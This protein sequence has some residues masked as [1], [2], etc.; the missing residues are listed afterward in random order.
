MSLYVISDLHG[1]YDLL[2]EMLKVINFSSSD[3]M[4]ILGDVV[5]RGNKPIDILLY[6]KDKPNIELL[7]GNHE[8]MFLDYIFSD[9]YFRFINRELYYKNGGFSTLQQFEALS[10]DTQIELLNYLKNLK[11]YK[12][13]NTKS[14]NFILV[15]S[16]LNLTGLDDLE[17][18]NKVM[19]I[20]SDSDLLW[21]REEFFMYPGIPN[22]RIIFGHTV[23]KYLY[24]YTSGEDKFDIWYDP[25]HKDKIR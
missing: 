18:I 2:K 8:D 14:G 11:K 12:I 19:S 21:S 17:D 16:G 4:F 15:H 23:T 6:I 22:Y 1:E 9:S 3:T 5:D 7:M 10:M 20:Q 25:V 13:V 24:S